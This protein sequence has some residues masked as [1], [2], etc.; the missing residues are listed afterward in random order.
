ME[1]TQHYRQKGSQKRD[2]DHRHLTVSWIREMLFDWSEF[3]MYEFISFMFVVAMK[4]FHPLFIVVDGIQYNY[5]QNQ[6]DSQ[7]YLT[8]WNQLFSFCNDIWID[9]FF[10]RWWVLFCFQTCSIVLIL[11]RLYDCS[12]CFFVVDF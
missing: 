9:I 11:N 7:Y 2:P 4:G 6:Y 1:V 3:M 8:Y 10:P 12:D 5:L